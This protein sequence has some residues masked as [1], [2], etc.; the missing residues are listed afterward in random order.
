MI[1]HFPL[2]D[3]VAQ[4]RLVLLVIATVKILNAFKYEIYNGFFK[5]IFTQSVLFL[6]GSMHINLSGTNFSFAKNVSW[7]EYGQNAVN[8]IFITSVC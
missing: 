3:T 7:K 4:Y 2:L 5:H 8:R 1:L 6:K